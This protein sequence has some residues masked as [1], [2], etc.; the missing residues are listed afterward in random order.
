[1]VMK[2]LAGGC[3]SAS[4]LFATGQCFAQIVFSKVAD[5]WG[6]IQSDPFGARGAPNGNRFWNIQGANNG[7]FASSGT[8]RFYMD[9]LLTQLDGQFG[10]GNWQ[11]DNVTLVVDQAP[12]GFSAPGLVDIF[13][14]T[15]DTIGFTNGEEST[16]T[17][18][19]DFSGLT[20]SPLV[21]NT[22][23]AATGFLADASDDQM[24][25]NPNLLGT[26][27]A[28]SQYSYANES[29]GSPD[30]IGVFSDPVD[31]TSAIPLSP[32]YSLTLPEA[33]DGLL[34]EFSWTNLQAII[35]DLEDGSDPLSFVFAPGDANVAATYKGGFN[36]GSYP[37]RI[38]IE[39]SGMSNPMLKGDTNNDGV[40]DTLDIDPFVLLLT[41]PNGY[42]TAF[43]TI[44]PLAVGDIN[45]DLVVDTLD[46]DPFV[47]L[48]TSGSLGSGG[49]AVPE[50]SSIVLLGVAGFGLLVRRK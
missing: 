48:L 38:F 45:M 50:P 17:P 23:A 27:T 21:F 15:N 2:L 7:T 19:S 20:R 46:I 40:V 25:P 30:S 42:V 9:D 43:P 4:L 12:A 22:N 35:D 33:M 10:S 8:L 13:H 11:I 32:S 1:M 36:E 5:E 49:G 28:V 16:D 39:A 24:N 6:T 14:V 18:P 31:P 34:S 47:A 44:D 26:V 41:D 29:A 37:P 3:L